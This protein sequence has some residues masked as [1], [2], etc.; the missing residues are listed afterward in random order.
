MSQRLKREESRG[1]KRVIEEEG[2]GEAR[3]GT[4]G[5]SR[6]DVEMGRQRTEA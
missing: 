3:R 6:G 1:E 5:G 4:M 2:K